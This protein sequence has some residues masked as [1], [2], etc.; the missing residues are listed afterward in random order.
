[1]GGFQIVKTIN[2]LVELKVGG[3]ILEGEYVAETT[4][5]KYD[6]VLYNGS[7][8]AALQET[9]GNLPTDTGYWVLLAEKGDDGANGQ[10]GEDGKNFEVD[11]YGLLE[12]RDDYDAEAEGFSYLATDTGDLYIREGSAG[13]WS[14]A[15]PF[16]G[17]KGDTGDTGPKGDTGPQGDQGEQGIQGP[18]G[19]TGSQG[20]EGAEGPQGPAGDKGD[21]G[22]KGD[23]GDTGASIVSAAFDDDDLVFTKDDTN[24]VVL[25][26]AKI[27]L[28]GDT[29]ETGAIGATGAKGDKGEKGDTG[30][31][32]IQ[33][34]Q[35]VQGVAGAT[36]A[37]GANGLDGTS[38][39]W[40]GDWTTSIFYDENDTVFYDGSSYICLAD[41]TSDDFATDLVADKWELMAQK[42]DDGGSGGGS[43]DDAF[44]IQL[45]EPAYPHFVTTG[46]AYLI[47]PDKTNGKVL[48]KIVAKLHAPG[49]G[50]TL[51]IKVF[52]ET[53][54]ITLGDSTTR[55]DIT[56]T[57]GT[58]WRYTYDATGTD[59]EIGDN[60]AVGDKVFINAQNFAANNNGTF[61]VT[62]K[63][64]AYFEV[65][66]TIG[67][68]ENDKTIGTG[69][70]KVVKCFNMLTTPVTIDPSEFSSEDAATAYVID[71]TLDDVETDDVIRIDIT[72]VHSTI[73]GRGLIMY[74]KFITPE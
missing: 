61:Y 8:Y 7:S 4:Y 64:T 70:I 35:G 23:K 54:D 52:K 38:F 65:S 2:P 19:A 47:I 33:G 50:G 21:T 68:A 36:G 32:G 73:P 42:G 44:I 69:S 51:E 9:T 3:L 43:S 28:K 25:E 67:T 12:D 5:A 15:I 29:G 74:L 49:I 48:S 27:D 26:D 53:S 16:Q 11:A 31:Q 13:N 40:K 18:T 63:D 6:V 66:K 14:S 72:G 57:S 45:G 62:A 39:V 71:T 10:D 59:P 46:R 1:M 55:F 20:P 22:P 37:T 56:N 60:V 58:T 30:S 17:P 24:T 41:H 34:I